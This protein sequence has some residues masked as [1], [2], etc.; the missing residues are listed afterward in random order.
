M[1]GSVR[2][3][4]S[5]ARR[6]AI[7]L[8][9]EL[10]EALRSRLVALVLL[11]YG[12]GAAIGAWLFLQAM[13]GAEQVAR[14]ALMQSLGVPESQ[15][16]E[17][18]VR[19]Q[20]LPGLISSVV[21]DPALRD[22]LLAM[23]PLAIFYGFMAL[24]VVSGLV[25]VTS[26]SAHASDLTTGAARFVLTRCDRRSWALGKAL[27]HAALL[28][29]GM[30]AGALATTAVAIWV[31]GTLELTTL[32]DLLKTSLWAWAYGACFVGIF[33]GVSLLAG[34][35]QRA[36]MLGVVALLALWLG[37]KLCALST[38]PGGAGEWL[39]WLFPAQYESLLWSPEPQR[40]LLALGALLGLGSMGLLL[41]A[42]VFQR[43]DA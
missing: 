17:D 36:R 20:A 1:T 2:T 6:V 8:G 22:Q 29:V 7:V 21:D 39:V 32:R 24:N 19:R 31:R 27:G 4:S 34:T 5:N 30:L 11:L 15:V 18:L 42:W 43:R 35:P 28:A 13:L 16:P 41:G 40:F 25:L 37:H 33:S 9:F 12:A 38:L 23:D 3:T 10:R 14:S 26:G